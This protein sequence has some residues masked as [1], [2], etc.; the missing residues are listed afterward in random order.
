MVSN[1]NF[2]LEFKTLVIEVLFAK[3]SFV[4]SFVSMRFEFNVVL[5][6]SRRRIECR[7]G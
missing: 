6:Q 1:S 7:V 5:D 3:P 4:G 2:I